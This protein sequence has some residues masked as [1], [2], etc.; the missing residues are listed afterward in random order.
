MQRTSLTLSVCE[1]FDSFTTSAAL[2]AF[3]FVADLGEALGAAT[4]GPVL[5]SGAAAAFALAVRAWAGAGWLLASILRF[6]A[7][8]AGDAGVD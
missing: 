1:S 6:L 3:A 7:L 8:R 5:A 4:L 2:S